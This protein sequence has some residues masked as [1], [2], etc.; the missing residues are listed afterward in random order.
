MSYMH[1]GQPQWFVVAYLSR[2]SQSYLHWPSLRLRLPIGQLTT[3]R[4][5]VCIYHIGRPDDGEAVGAF[6]FAVETCAQFGRLS[7]E[8]ALVR[9]LSKDCDYGMVE[10][11]A[12]DPQSG[13]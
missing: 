3:E 5:L 2:I 4:P 7:G 13:P 9:E 11:Y 8:A 10:R 1:C 12:E 6:E